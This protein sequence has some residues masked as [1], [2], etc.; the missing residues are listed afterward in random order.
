MFLSVPKTVVAGLL[1]TLIVGVSPVLAQTENLITVTGRAEIKVEPDEA[2]L[3]VIIRESDPI[4]A[5]ALSR[6]KDRMLNIKSMASNWGVSAEEMGIYSEYF[7]PIRKK[8]DKIEG[9]EISK[10]ITIRLRDMSRLDDLLVSLYSAGINDIYDISFQVSDLA[11]YRNQA[12]LMAVRAA[13]KK[14]NDL[15]GEL[16]LTAAAPHDL[17]IEDGLQRPPYGRYAREYSSPFNVSAEIRESGL[18]S[19]SMRTPGKVSVIATVTVSFEME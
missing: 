13:V 12:R 3:T 1:S 17:N 10:R 6:M 15:T 18:V 14:A 11:E 5:E 19:D 9:Y 16:G 8:D 7:R 2:Y 4:P